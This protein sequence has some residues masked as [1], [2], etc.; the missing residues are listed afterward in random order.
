LGVTQFADIT[1]AEFQALYVGPKWDT[2]K[3]KN[4]KLPKLNEVNQSVQQS[5][6]NWVAAGNVGP[7]NN[8]GQCGSC[9]SFSAAESIQSALSLNGQG[10]PQ[11]SE[12]Q[13]VQCSGSFGNEGCNGGWP[14]QAYEYVMSNPLNLAS[15]YPYTSGTGVTG[16]C[17]AALEAKGTYKIST[18][19][20]VAASCASLQNALVQQPISVCVD[21]SNWS[22]LYYGGIFPSS[23]CG[24]Q[25]DHAVLLTGT[26]G[27]TYWTIQNS[28]ASS[29]G[30]NGY[31]QLQYGDSCAVCDYAVYPVA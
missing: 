10:L 5:A 29:W 17:N 16:N 8:Q 3:L 15:A 6:V 26:D 25:V 7:V 9:W 23:E 24:D 1:Q 22:A 18:Y 12:E 2:T 28:W 31:I 20:T 13:L 19:E 4:S 21:A 27:A 30:E 14:Y 11:L